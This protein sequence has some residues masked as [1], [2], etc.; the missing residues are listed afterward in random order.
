M[1][2]RERSNNSAFSQD[3]DRPIRR[4]ALYARVS[5]LNNQDPENRSHQATNNSAGCK[6]P[7]A[8]WKEVP[9]VPSYRDYTQ[10][11]M[12]TSGLP[13][14]TSAD[15]LFNAPPSTPGRCRAL[16]YLAPTPW[17]RTMKLQTPSAYL[18]SLREQLTFISL[19]QLYRSC[20]EVVPK[21]RPRSMN[22][23][24]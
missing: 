13:Y 12:R 2:R 5:T 20:T 6:R 3:T 23:V 16:L 11:K 18:V 21:G 1:A 8:P 15:A 17:S 22:S 4:V 9:E 24:R 7:S 14:A 19:A 10:C